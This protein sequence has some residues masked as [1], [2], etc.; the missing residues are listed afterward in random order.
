MT[1]KLLLSMTLS[2][3]ASGAFA[4]EATSQPT[5]Q[6]ASSP[7]S[8][9]A[10]QPASQ[11]TTTITA[12]PPTVEVHQSATPQITPK[13][14]RSFVQMEW[15]AFFLADHVSHGP[16][17][18][19]GVN[20]LGGHLRIGLA[21]FGRPGPWNPA[22]FQVKLADGVTYKDKD[23]LTLRSD[24]GML[25]LYTSGSIRLQK[26][27]VS[28]ELP[29][30]LGFGG[31]GFYLQGEDRITPDGD[32][33][34]VWE[35]RLFNDTDSYIGPMLESGLRVTLTEQSARPYVGVQ[36]TLMP[37]FETMVRE[38]YSGLSVA[39]GVALGGL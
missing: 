27:P 8:Q 28:L 5:S 36:Y 25:G 12:S 2:C 34:S 26:L 23:T 37:G 20:L 18:S 32:R 15:R 3:I 1:P 22:E 31:F 13:P 17:F 35:D 6:P 11:L 29:I 14:S 16:A 4:Q 21:G 10:S 9:A 19:A 24:G 39:L 7:S 30:T 38:G 33:V